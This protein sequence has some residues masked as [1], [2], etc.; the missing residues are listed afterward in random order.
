MTKEELYRLTEKWLNGTI[1]RDEKKMLDAWYYLES[2]EETEVVINQSDYAYKN[3]TELRDGLFRKIQEGKT[4]YSASK[5]NHKII[6]RVVA[7]AAAIILVITSA[8][9]FLPDQ[10]EPV[11]ISASSNSEQ[12]IL[13]GKEGAI[14]TLSD[15]SKIILD[16][17][18][19]GKIAKEGASDIEL[20]EGQLFYNADNKIEN[21][22][23]TYNTMTTPKGRQ[24]NVVLP[25]G[26][27]VWLNAESELVFPTSF[28]NTSRTVKLTGEAY[29]E[30]TSNHTPFKV[31]VNDKE[32]IVVHGT[33]FN[34]KAYSTEADMQTTLLEGKVSVHSGIHEKILQPG[35]Q[36]LV[37]KE[38][39]H[40]IISKADIE[41][42]MAWKNGLFN[43]DDAE[44]KEVMRQLSRWYDIEVVYEEGV[45]DIVFG[46]EIKRN[47]SLQDV[48]LALESTKV[49]FRI[50]QNRK[51]VLLP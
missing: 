13:P 23:I 15:G 40:I 27:H 29:F 36:A 16:S 10:K 1:S 22:S 9:Y 3:E 4:I 6:K 39:P 41:K 44:L 45:P 38:S 20:K 12:E 49:H 11:E 32:E 50:E 5:F 43:F 30:V 25:D 26:T 19:N 47:I 35:Q 28:S 51:L 48:L 46:G 31:I 14:L 21:S 18:G 2:R 8:I 33:K 42:A 17:L 37:N 7:V 24:F 34:I